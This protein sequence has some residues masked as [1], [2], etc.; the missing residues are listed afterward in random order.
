MITDI[1][2][3]RLRR[4]RGLAKAFW[5]KSGFGVV[6]ATPGFGKTALGIIILYQQFQKKG[7]SKVIILA[8]SPE[9]KAHWYNNLKDI[10]P[11]WKNLDIKIHTPQESVNLYKKV[12]ARDRRG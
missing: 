9:N 2:E 12:P 11:Y 3:T 10:G 8:S 7:D 4:Q 5:D 1:Q 6:V